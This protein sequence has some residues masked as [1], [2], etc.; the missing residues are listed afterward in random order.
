M[1]IVSRTVPIRFVFK[2][3]DEDALLVL[4]LLAAV[5][6]LGVLIRMVLHKQ[7][8]TV[9]KNATYRYALRYGALHIHEIRELAKVQVPRLAR[10]YFTSVRYQGA[11]AEAENL[12]DLIKDARLEK[13]TT[14][15]R[16]RWAAHYD[17]E[18]FE[19]ALSF[20]DRGD[21]MELPGRGMHF[22]VCDILF[23]QVLAHESHQ[24]FKGEKIEDSVKAA[25]EAILDL[26]R[27]LITVANALVFALYDHAQGR[28]RTRA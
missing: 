12:K 7:G 15:A 17:K 6:D 25:L 11:L 26:Q 9:E 8:T 19:R 28:L 23:D 3:N 21:L 10:R 22:N 5:N 18:Y 1:G 24:A 13:V 20:I 27:A 16:K 14:F 4:R 2:P